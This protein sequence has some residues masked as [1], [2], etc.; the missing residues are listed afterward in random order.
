VKLVVYYD[1][2]YFSPTCTAVCRFCKIIGG[3]VK[4]DSKEDAMTRTTISLEPSLLKTVKR[5]AHNEG[6]TLGRE[7]SELLSIG[8]RH[9]LQRKGSI[10]KS[11]F[12][13]KSFSMGRE[14]ISLEDKDGLRSF[15]EKDNALHEFL[16]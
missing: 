9:K 13:L 11:S 4:G 14:K 5:L 7:I 10:P 1:K 16:R 15:L 12:K 3:H 8:L 6:A 2:Y